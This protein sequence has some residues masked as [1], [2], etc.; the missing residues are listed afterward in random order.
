MLLTLLIIGV[1]II[2]HQPFTKDTNRQVT[3]AA[4]CVSNVVPSGM[5]ALMRLNKFANYQP[6]PLICTAVLKGTFVLS[7]C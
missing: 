6:H 3:D 5:Q 1:I 2:L 4:Y 7:H